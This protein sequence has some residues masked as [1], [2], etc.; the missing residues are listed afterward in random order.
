VL[1]ASSPLIASARC[2]L[3]D[4]ARALYLY[5]GAALIFEASR[6]GGLW[7]SR[8]C[9]VAGAVVVNHGSFS[10]GNEYEVGIYSAWRPCDS[11]TWR[12]GV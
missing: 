4:H 9:R 6:Q 8:P 2:W 10:P 12:D 1:T 7:S 11:L 5:S 3:V